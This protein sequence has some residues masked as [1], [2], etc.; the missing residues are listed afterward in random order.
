MRLSLD[1]LRHSRGL[2]ALVPECREQGARCGEED[3]FTR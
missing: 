1:R 3:A 2:L